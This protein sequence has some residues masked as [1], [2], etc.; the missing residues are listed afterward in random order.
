MKIANFT[1]MQE[2]LANENPKEIV[3]DGSCLKNLPDQVPKVV[4]DAADAA[5]VHLICCAKENRFLDFAKRRLLL[6]H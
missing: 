5:D 3:K 4:H 1:M 6:T 2:S